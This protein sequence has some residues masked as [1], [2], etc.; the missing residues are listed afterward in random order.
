MSIQFGVNVVVA[1][2]DAVKYLGLSDDEITRQNA[3][4]GETKQSRSLIVSHYTQ[5]RPFLAP[6]LGRLCKRPVPVKRRRR[7]RIAILGARSL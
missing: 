6:L 7:I 1:F 4:E 2:L 5:L 3:A